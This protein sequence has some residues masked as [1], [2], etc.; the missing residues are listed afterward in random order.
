M[1]T[2]YEARRCAANKVICMGIALE[3][4]TERGRH[5]ALGLCVFDRLC[6][7]TEGHVRGLKL[8]VA[9]WNCLW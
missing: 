4:S 1:L 6:G 7:L 8:T 5:V 9:A 2:R 3:A